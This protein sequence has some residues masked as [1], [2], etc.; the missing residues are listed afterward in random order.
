MRVLRIEEIKGK[1][2]AEVARRA[3]E[4][5][6]LEIKDGEFKKE[7]VSRALKAS[8]KSFIESQKESE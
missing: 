2:Y 5:T 8:L 4:T 1:Q 3:G 7:N 6:F